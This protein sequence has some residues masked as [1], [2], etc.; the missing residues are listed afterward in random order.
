MAFSAEFESQTHLA[1]TGRGVE[2]GFM[3]QCDAMNRF[4][5]V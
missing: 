5:H 4:F 3:G 2:I 1:M